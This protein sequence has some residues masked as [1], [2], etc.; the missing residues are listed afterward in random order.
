MK[1]YWGFVRQISVEGSTPSTALQMCVGLYRSMY[2]QKTPCKTRTRQYRRIIRNL[3]ADTNDKFMRMT[4]F[5]SVEV[6]IK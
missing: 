6:L 3:P 1:L 5:K 4:P 2:N